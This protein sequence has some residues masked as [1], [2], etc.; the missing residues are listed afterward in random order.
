M[1]MGRGMERHRAGSRVHASGQR[2]A[3]GCGRRWSHRCGCAQGGQA[4]EH[5]HLHTMPM[6]PIAAAHCPRPRHVY[7]HAPTHPLTHP[8]THP[9]NRLSGPA[10]GAGGAAERPQGSAGAAAGAADAEGRGAGAGGHGGGA[11]ERGR[12]W[13]EGAWVWGGACVWGV[14][15]GGVAGGGCRWGKG[16]GGWRGRGGGGGKVGGK[17]A[18]VSGCVAGRGRASFCARE[19]GHW[20]A[21]PAGQGDHHLHSSSCHTPTRTHAP[22]HYHLSLPP[23]F[24]PH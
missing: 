4:A 11:G 19:G 3:K 7:P 23:P 18:R 17:G 24:L 12:W 16:G 20:G 10:Q 6:I 21:E 14:G 13:G 1:C 9:P 2:T 15:L 22:T 8:P 5:A